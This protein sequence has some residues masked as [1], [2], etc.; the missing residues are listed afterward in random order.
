MRCCTIMRTTD[1]AQHAEQAKPDYLSQKP[2]GAKSGWQLLET[3]YLYQDKLT[4]LRR[5]RIEIAGRDEMSYAYCERAASVIIVPVTPDGEMILLR[6]YLYPV[7][8]WCLEVPAGG[9]HDTGDMPLEDV[10]RKELEEEIGGTCQRLE[11]ITW[12]YESNALSDQKCHVYLALGVELSEQPKTEKT[13]EIEIQ[14]MPVPEALELARS[15]QMKT[16]PC[17]LAVLLCEPALRRDS[18]V[19][20]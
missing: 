16:G 14:R 15:G 1:Q 13:E 5:D 19:D 6:Q 8:D 18:V 2:E 11:Y 12:F 7:D 4:K 17:T 10:V 9:T 3:K 20:A